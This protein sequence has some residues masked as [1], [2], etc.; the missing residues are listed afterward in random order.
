MRPYVFREGRPVVRPHSPR[1][2]G[3]VDADF[4]PGLQ[5]TPQ[6]EAIACLRYP[7]RAAEVPQENVV[8]L[9]PDDCRLFCDP[10]GVI[11]ADEAI[12]GPSQLHLEDVKYAE[13]APALAVHPTVPEFAGRAVVAAF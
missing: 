4:F 2:V 7:G 11:E 8:G 10:S 5:A 9:T 13:A 6:E 3:I 1:P 12:V